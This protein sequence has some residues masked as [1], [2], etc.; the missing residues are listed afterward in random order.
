MP[1]TQYPPNLVPTVEDF[2]ACGWKTAVATADPWDYRSISDA[3]F[4]AAKTP[5]LAERHAKALWLLAG[6]RSMRLAA[7]SPNE[8][9]TPAFSSSTGRSMHPD[10][11]TET[12]ITSFSLAVGEIDKALPGAHLLKAR[13]ADLVWLV[14][15]PRNIDFALAAIDSYRSVP[16]DA[17]TW[18]LSALDCWQR[19]LRLARMCSRAASGRLLQMESAL[20][21]RF[22]AARTEDGFLRLKVADLMKTNSLAKRQGNSIATGLRDF[23]HTFDTG[24]DFHKARSYFQGATNW[25]KASADEDNAM[26]TLVAK[27]DCWVKEAD[28]RLSSTDP[29][30]AVAASFF[31]SAIQ[32][33]RRVPR[34]QRQPLG[35]E[36]RLDLL[37][38]RLRDAG[39]GAAEQM[40]S[41]DGPSIDISEL[42]HAAREAVAGKTQADALRAFVSLEPWVTVE[43]LRSDALDTL[44]RYPLQ[45]LF[46][47]SVMSPDGR[48]V[49]KY[50]GAAVNEAATD[51]DDAAV[52]H[53]MLSAHSLHVS[54]AVQAKIL[55]ALETLRCEHRIREFEFIELSKHASIAPDGRGILIGKSLFAGY[56]GDFATALHLLVPQVEH[57][58]RFHLNRAGVGTRHLDD[59][60]IETE[61]GLNALLAVPESTELFGPDLIFEISVVFADP[62][63]PNLRNLVAHGLLDEATAS[64]S[65]HTV[66]A[67]W[68]VLKL[69]F[70]A[71][72]NSLSAKKR[73]TT[74]AQDDAGDDP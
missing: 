6:A 52:H 10:D 56:D 9:F 3:L 20:L 45:A 73:Q 35:V 44:R 62:G 19:A 26:R 21:D 72:W 28:T 37:N 55:P 65:A 70:L 29:S 69:V 64:Y 68:L 5:D 4:V 31:E 38:E 47:S 49:A 14:G 57:M 30:H 7:T 54:L 2:S 12:D 60:G 58:L 59:K 36:D 17:Q 53:Q 51:T 23:G 22:E 24:H 15:Q 74:G 50:P 39:K 16:L 67:W 66:Y 32:T 18:F 8:P 43:K 41:I 63:G 71:F 42:V 27:A 46:P 25:F 48:V 33:L 1:H 11:L 13:L 61:K 40:S 34:S